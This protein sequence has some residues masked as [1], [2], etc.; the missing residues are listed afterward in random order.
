MRLETVHF[1][2]YF[3]LAGWGTQQDG[4]R[5]GVRWGGGPTYVLLNGHSRMHVGFVGQCNRTI[6]V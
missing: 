6:E 5:V 4:P 2:M 1:F 3:H